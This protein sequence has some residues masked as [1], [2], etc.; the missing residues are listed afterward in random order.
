MNVQKMV[1]MSPKRLMPKESRDSLSLGIMTPQEPDDDVPPKG[2]PLLLFLLLFL[3]LL[4]LLLFFFFY[5][6]FFSTPFLRPC[7]PRD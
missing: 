1:E 4:L 7:V 5:F 2:F 3:L 6:F